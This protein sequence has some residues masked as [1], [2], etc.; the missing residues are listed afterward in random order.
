MPG[1]RAAE[2]VRRDQILAAAFDV[3]VGR[4]VAAMTV[5][6]VATEAGVSAGLILFHFASKRGL[7][8]G[9][10]E[11][12]LS[13]TTVLAVPSAHLAAHP[14]EEH[15][16]VALVD[17]MRRLAADP[18][19]TRVM[20]DFWSL[21]VRDAEIRDRMGQEFARYR[22][23]FEPLAAALIA[24]AP[25]RFG[26]LLPSSLAAVAASFV[27]GCAVQSMIAGAAFDIDDYLLTAER[28]FR[29]EGLVHPAGTPPARRSRKRDSGG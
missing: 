1:S 19:R 24:G 12:L 23:A 4:G 22:R 9:L 17:E 11:R 18:G 27:K 29:A 7:Q 2:A 6:E 13:S 14:P 10:L 25:D 15:L 8:L 20:F 5:A 26:D 21:G 28:L 16:L 3:A